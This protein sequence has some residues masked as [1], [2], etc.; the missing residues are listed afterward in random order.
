MDDT[1]DIETRVRR[2]E[3]GEKIIWGLGSV[4]AALITWGDDIKKWFN[5]LR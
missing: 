5:E 1:K 2:L 3:K 4:L